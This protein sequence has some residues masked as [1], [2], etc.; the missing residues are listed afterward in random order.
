MAVRIAQGESFNEEI[1]L[2]T[3]SKALPK[4][5]KLLNL[6]SFI[7]NDTVLWVEGQLERSDFSYNKK[8]PLI[9]DT[10]VHVTYLLFKDEHSRNLHLGPESLSYNTIR[11]V[12]WVISGRNSVKRVVRECYTCFRHKPVTTEQFMG[13]L[14]PSRV[15][16]ANPFYQVRVDYGGLFLIK[17]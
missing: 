1:N 5:S 3:R 11:G 7:D 14:P 6:N 15:Q 8:H 12:F 10:S 16:R 9:L 2:L 13:H 17:K 4:D